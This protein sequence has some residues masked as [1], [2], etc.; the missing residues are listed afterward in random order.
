MCFVLVKSLGPR[1]DKAAAPMGAVMS[2]TRAAI[3]STCNPSSS[4]L[5]RERD[6]AVSKAIGP[7]AAYVRNK[8]EFI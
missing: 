4:C 7:I 2:I 3:V 1:K 5:G 6:R 8:T